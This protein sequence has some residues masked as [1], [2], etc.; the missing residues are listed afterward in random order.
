MHKSCPDALSSVPL[1]LGVDCRTAPALRSIRSNIA[2]GLSAYNTFPTQFGG[3]RPKKF[4]DDLYALRGYHCVGADPLTPADV[5]DRETV[6]KQRLCLFG[7]KVRP[8]NRVVA[9]SRQRLPSRQCAEL[10]TCRVNAGWTAL[11][12]AEQD[13]D[14]A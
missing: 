8:S 6:T 10:S 14:R 3:T 11:L 13:R 12:G 2:I 1:G 4:R 5:V 9:P 7:S